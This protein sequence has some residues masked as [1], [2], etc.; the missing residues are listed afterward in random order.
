[1]SLPVPGANE[2]V[3]PFFRALAW[4]I[5]ACFT[6]GALG[7]LWAV[8]FDATTFGERAALVV[9]ILVLGLGTWAFLLAAL[10]RNA[11]PPG[12]RLQLFQATAV[13]V[14][15]AGIAWE[16]FYR[17][18]TKS[19]LVWLTIFAAMSLSWLYSFF[20]GRALLRSSR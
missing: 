17:P 3:R 11:K 14:C 6:F 2:P 7:G 20:S 12:P 19:Q 9:L 1:M 15:L 10:G 8:I 5:V 13:V 4:I 18:Q 16:I